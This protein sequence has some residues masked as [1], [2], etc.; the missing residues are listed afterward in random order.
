LRNSAVARVSNGL[1][2]LSLVGLLCAVVPQTVL[3]QAISAI[4]T[5]SF[6]GRIYQADTDGNNRQTLITGDFLNS[7][8]LIL[9]A[10]KL[11]WPDAERG[12][13]QRANTDGS[14]LE[15]VIAVANAGALGLDTDGGKLYWRDTVAN[16]IH[17]CNLDG[18]S[19]ELVLS[20][21][22]PGQ[23]LTVAVSSQYIF[24]DEY[25]SGGL[26][27]GNVYR[28]SIA[29][30][31]PQLISQYQASNSAFGMI[32]DE[33]NSHIYFADGKRIYRLDTNGANFVQL[34]AD[35][36]AIVA[37][38]IDLATAKLF[39][40][41]NSRSDVVR[42]NLDGSNV[43]VLDTYELNVDG[44]VVDAAN[45]KLYWSQDRYIV[46]ADLDGSNQ[47]HPLARAAFYSVAID[48]ALGRIYYSD[49]NA[50]ETYYADLDGS[51]QTLFWS[52][53]GGLVGSA[54]TI[55]IDTF[56]N[57]VYWLAGG[58]RNLRRADPDGSN[59]ELVTYLPGD[60]YDFALDL[61]NDRVYW[62][63]R[64]SGM[65]FRKTLAA[66]AAV[67]TLFT[68]LNFP[69]NIRL[70]YEHGRVI[71]GEDDQIAHGDINGGGPVTTCFTSLFVV[72]GLAWDVADSRL[73][74]A[75]ELNSR[76]QRAIYNPGSDDWQ[77][78]ETIFAPGVNNWPGR[79]VLQYGYV[80]GVG[81][82]VSPVASRHFA[83]PNPFNPATTIH[84]SLPQAASVTVSIYDLV[85]RKVRVIHNDAW[86]ASGQQAVVWSGQDDDGRLMASGVYM[87]RINAGE[88]A[89]SGKL[90]LVK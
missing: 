23:S 38:A 44:I 46:Q 52:G 61:P 57:R 42:S 62:C 82:V 27:Q 63:G 4:W 26:L 45:A 49:F 8:H 9:G 90:V 36:D 75:E 6:T 15:T 39:W 11:Y 41:D 81:D 72:Q 16:E 89:M 40:A 80:S 31:K 33:T 56:Q 24:W 28:R 88:E 86:L 43:E 50:G 71:W 66:A 70:D 59:V 17:R 65:I 18:S 69:K 13:I 79:L 30:G 5:D 47:S 67:D 19:P 35:G 74:W 51:N 55:E 83:A 54:V 32:V 77:P 64:F 14:N 78:A 53:I 76:V 73:Y 60:A 12:L 37:V 85:G 68:G 1:V 7:A 58:D 3:G 84:F 10:G 22:N 25:D 2:S 34:H 48:E 87:Y 21:A 29:G 20:P